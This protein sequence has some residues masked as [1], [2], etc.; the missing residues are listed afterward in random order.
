MSKRKASSSLSRPF[1]APRKASLSKGDYQKGREMPKAPKT[2]LKAF[3]V[4]STNQTFQVAGSFTLL[5]ACVNGAELYQR[6]GRKIYMKSLHVRGFISNTVTVVQDYGRILVIY[7]SQANK[8]APVIGDILGDSNA[9][10]G[11]TGN[12]EI[13]LANR[14]RFKILRDYPI[15]LPSA[16]FAAGVITNM[17]QVNTV[18]NDFNIDMFIPLKGLETVFNAVNGGTILD[19]ASGSLYLICVSQL[20]AGWELSATTRLRYY[21]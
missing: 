5:N 10:A 9:G 14:E 21:D 6:V 17:V 3:D 1:K 18:K 16:T 11:Q 4:S 13:N 19:I 2:E 20:A 7:D 12:S 8:A 15:V